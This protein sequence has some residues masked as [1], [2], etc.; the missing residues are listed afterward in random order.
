MSISRAKIRVH[1]YFCKLWQKRWQ[2]HPKYRQTRNWFPKLNPKRSDQIM[3]LSR[4]EAAMVIQFCTGFNNLNYH[5]WN[6]Q[7]INSDLCRL[8]GDDR[9]EA[10]HL[11]KDYPALCQLQMETFGLPG[12][13]VWNVPCL[14]NFIQSD[15]VYDLLHTRTTLADE[16]FSQYSAG[17]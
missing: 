7:E 12:P 10:W 14:V 4:S 15:P 17:I 6:K 1:D 13:T 16:Y 2:E 8:C 3:R 5:S 9:K 11:A